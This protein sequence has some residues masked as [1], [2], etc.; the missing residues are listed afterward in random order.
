MIATMGRNVAVVAK[1]DVSSVRNII[2]AV[3][4]MINN[5]I[6]SPKGIIFPI[7]AARPVLCAAAASDK[8]PPNNN[9]TPH[10]T[11]SCASFHSRRF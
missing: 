2:K 9:K 6:L 11:P 7:Q 10:G 5:A 8:P 4:M 1:L 3:N